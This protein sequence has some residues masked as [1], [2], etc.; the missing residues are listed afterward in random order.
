MS[1]NPRLLSVVVFSLGLALAVSA[2]AGAGSVTPMKPLGAERGVSHPQRAGRGARHELG[3]REQ[4]R[5]APA[6]RQGSDPSGSL[7]FCR[8]GPPGLLRARSVR[9]A[10]PRLR[11]PGLVPGRE[12]R[13]RDATALGS[14]DRPHVDREPAAPSEPA[15]PWLPSCRRR[16]SG[17]F[18][19]ASSR[20]TSPAADRTR[21]PQ[22]LTSNSR[23]SARR[24]RR[25][26]C[27]SPRSTRSSRSLTSGARWSGLNGLVT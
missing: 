2:R 12:P 7:A 8:H 23:S 21:A 6:D 14:R 27:T 11:R 1:G 24:S 20:P 10:A 19:I 3:P 4:R 5:A 15:R 13:L 9:T 22:S 16:R 25:R 26:S 17:W 18:R